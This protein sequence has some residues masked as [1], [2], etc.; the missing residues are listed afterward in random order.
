MGNTGI[1]YF[2]AV[3]FKT[4]SKTSRAREFTR[5]AFTFGRLDLAQAE[6]VADLIDAASEKALNSAV[7]QLKGGLSKPLINCLT[8]S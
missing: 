5:R 7:S 3:D 4:R 2:V 8:N 6:A 1:N